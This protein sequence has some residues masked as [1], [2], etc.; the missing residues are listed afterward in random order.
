MYHP[1]VLNEQVYI[2]MAFSQP[3]NH[4][5]FNMTDFQ[6]ISIDANSY[7]YTLDMFSI[8]YSQI[9][10]SLYRIYIEP[11]GYIFLYNATFRVTTNTYA[12]VLDYSTLGYPFDLNNYGASSSLTWFVIKGAEF[13]EL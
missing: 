10:T 3:L 6:T 12:G 8:T 1:S 5:T 13:S 4:S 9:S 7:G 11:K 2:D